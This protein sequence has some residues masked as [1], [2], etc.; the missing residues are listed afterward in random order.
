METSHFYFLVLP[1]GILVFVLAP[2]VFYYSRK[3]ERAQRKLKKLK[4][5]FAR[6]RLKQKEVFTRQLKK[7][8][9]LS[10]SKS[11]DEITYERL[12]KV[13]END[14]AQKR[15]KAQVQLS[16]STSKNGSSTQH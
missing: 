2:L 5:T 14:Y 7:L 11:I 10:Q 6:N 4:S 13:L 1:L 12:K 3:E 9:E 8:D 16:S 15:E